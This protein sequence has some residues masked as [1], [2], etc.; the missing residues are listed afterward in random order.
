M[1]L[2]KMAFSLNT[3]F[4]MPEGR[5]IKEILL[6]GAP[7]PWGEW[8]TKVYATL[9]AP[10]ALAHRIPL[11]EALR[12]FCQEETEEHY[13]QVVSLF[14]EMVKEDVARRA[15]HNNGAE[16]DDSARRMFGDIE[17]IRIKMLGF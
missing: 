15:Q 7:L 16:W 14:E 17:S 8:E 3:F 10:L 4:E 1:P 5:L 13:Q 2:T 6:R 11:Y 12:A 9:L